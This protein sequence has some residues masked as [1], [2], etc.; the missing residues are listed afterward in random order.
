M[1]DLPR[2]NSMAAVGSNTRASKLKYYEGSIMRQSNEEIYYRFFTN[3]DVLYD[4]RSNANISD[5]VAV[6]SPREIKY[7][8]KG[9]KYSIDGM[10]FVH[11]SVKF[12]NNDII[13]I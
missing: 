5:V 6:Y 8:D 10:I 13:T 2:F 3:T 11:D 7:L 12:P 1:G 9:S 4:P